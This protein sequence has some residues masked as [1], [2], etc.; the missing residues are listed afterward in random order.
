MTG[1]AT[2]AEAAPPIASPKADRLSAL[3]VED[4]EIFRES[5]GQLVSREGFRQ[6]AVQCSGRGAIAAA[7][8]P[9]RA[10]R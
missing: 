8:G 2:A 4:D 9:E 10:G 3:I 7:A 1:K 5:L 6:A